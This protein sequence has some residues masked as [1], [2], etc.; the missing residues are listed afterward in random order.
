L[1]NGNSEGWFAILDECQIV[2]PLENPMMIGPSFCLT[3]KRH[4]LLPFLLCAAVFPCQVYAES[5][6]GPQY[7]QVSLLNAIDSARVK[8]GQ[9]VEAEAAFDWQS[10][11]C[12]LHQGALLRGHVVDVQ[13]ATKKLNDSFV[14]FSIDQADCQGYR[15]SP[16]K[17]QVVEIIGASPDN[18]PGRLLDVLPKRGSGLSAGQAP[19]SAIVLRPNEPI[20]VH[21]GEVQGMKDVSLHLGAGPEGS[22]LVTASGGN[23]HL[24]RNTVMVLTPDHLTPIELK[25]QMKDQ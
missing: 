20:T 5:G 24:G 23:L 8:P 17:L 2:L 12:I 9:S 19:A 1:R 11:T 16:L 14:A 4:Y 3:H 15:A 22:T 6:K 18:N 7:L 21:P 13:K 25:P 10:P